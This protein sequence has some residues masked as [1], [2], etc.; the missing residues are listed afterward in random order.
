MFQ[1]PLQFLNIIHNT[2]KDILGQSCKCGLGAI[3]KCLNRLDRYGIL[4]SV[5]DENMSLRALD[6]YLRKGGAADVKK[7]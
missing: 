1:I 2:T 3:K 6:K 5:R 4:L 7:M